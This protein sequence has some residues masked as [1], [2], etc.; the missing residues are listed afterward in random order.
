[1]TQ[2]H[3]WLERAWE[4]E[5]QIVFV[6]GEPGIGKTTLVQE[7]LRQEQAAPEERLWVAR[8]QCIEHYGTGEGYLPRL[9]ALGRLC[10]EPGGGQLVELLDKHAPAW[11]AQMP[12]LLESA[13][14]KELQGKAAGATHA[15]MLRELAEA[16]EVTEDQAQRRPTGDYES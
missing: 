3:Q 15:R 14:W 4:H 12:A 2:L 7:F 9:D 13:K 10:R 11:L 6:T 1:L 16:I 5:R 8:G